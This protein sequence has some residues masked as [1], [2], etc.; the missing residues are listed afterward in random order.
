[1]GFGTHASWKV[2]SKSEIWKVILKSRAVM[3][4]TSVIQMHIEQ[5]CEYSNYFCLL[6]IWH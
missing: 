2:L 4:S 6:I 3:L 5:Y 1:M